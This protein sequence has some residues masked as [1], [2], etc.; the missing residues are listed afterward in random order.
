MK[1][2]RSDKVRIATHLMTDTETRA[3]T[4]RFDS[5]GWQKRKEAIVAR[6]KKQRIMAALRVGLINRKAKETRINIAN[7]RRKRP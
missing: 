6:V 2:K 3:G 1:I 5:A 7:A 4:S